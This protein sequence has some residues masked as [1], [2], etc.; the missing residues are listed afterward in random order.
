ME[1]PLP[2]PIQNGSIDNEELIDTEKIPVKDSEMVPEDFPIYGTCKEPPL[3]EPDVEVQGVQDILKA[4]S[5]EE[6]N[7]LP[8]ENMPLRHFRAEKVRYFCLLLHNDRGQ[9][10]TSQNEKNSG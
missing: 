2:S 6:R 7:S 10:R 5:E 8:D 9:L 4:L 3:L 1:E